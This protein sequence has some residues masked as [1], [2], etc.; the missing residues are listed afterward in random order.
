[1]RPWVDFPDKK[2]ASKVRR[3][4]LPAS[5]R[6]HCRLDDQPNFL[7]PSRLCNA[8][9]TERRSLGLNPGV[10]WPARGP[11]PAELAAM[12]SFSTSEGD[13]ELWVADDIRRMWLAFSVGPRCASILD[14]LF[15]LK[16]PVAAFDD[17]T[18]W[19]LQTAQILIEADANGAA[20]AQVSTARGEST[21][22]Y[23]THGHT[24]L[25]NM[26]NPL[27]IG[28]MRRYFRQRVR[29]GAFRL[30]DQSSP[31]RYVA[32]NNP[33]ARFL[34]AQLTS[35]VG[36]I[37]GEPLKPSYVYFSAY[38]G[39]AM[40]RKHIDRPQ[41]A[42]TLS[43]LLDYS[44]EPECESPWPLILHTD[45]GPR[46]IKQGIGDGVLFRG[47]VIPHERPPLEEN[48]SSASL[49]FHYVSRSFSGSLD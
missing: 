40:L 49:L 3:L 20:R 13:Q 12:P 21:K 32:H 7:V 46:S 19:L 31:G 36:A 14:S 44:P 37:A 41:C 42:H 16:I 45:E 26:I 17:A 6:F 11:R 27:L 39:G 48:A 28:A 5:D 8:T 35:L 10:W 38:Q 18:V 1:M 23:S 24:C 30:G 29:S 43:L 33:V 22:E 2:T 25:R 4:D 15:T 47:Q 34:H 9:G